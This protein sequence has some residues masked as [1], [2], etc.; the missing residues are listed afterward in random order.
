MCLYQSQLMELRMK[1]D[2]LKF[3]AKEKSDNL[4]MLESRLL[5]T[6][7]R[8]KAAGQSA[9]KMD[10]LLEQIRQVNDETMIGRQRSDYYKS[11]LRHC[12]VNP[13]RDPN[14]IESA[15]TIVN[16]LKQDIV[17]LQ[18]KT[19]VV[20]YEK[21]LASIEVPKLLQV[22]QDKSN[23]HQAALARLRWRQELNHRMTSNLIATKIA[24]FTGSKA[25][26]SSNQA[27]EF[28]DSG[29]FGSP[30]KRNTISGGGEG[31]SAAGAV[32]GAPETNNFLDRRTTSIEEA[33]FLRAKGKLLH[34]KETSAERQKKV[35]SLKQYIGSA[36]KDDGILGTLRQVGI[37]KPEEA[38]VYWQ[39][40]LDHATQLEAEEKLGEQ[41][42][43][44][45]REKLTAL[46]A[47]F[48]NLKLGGSST[49]NESSSSAVLSIASAG[50]QSSC[51][52]NSGSTN[53]TTPAGGASGG[54]E[55]VS[56]SHNIKLLEQ[57]LAE[58]SANNQQKK[59]R[60]ARLKLLSE[61]SSTD[62]V[63]I[64]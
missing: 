47:Q 12:E 46:Q 51:G 53:T 34:K 22:I 42:V 21:R 18:Q 40:Q 23:I 17:D 8:A 59:E 6:K 33:S 49:S 25:N 44:E 45:Y 14:T 5:D 1:Y 62:F 43:M 29:G 19:Q 28:R 15:E 32:A 61:V 58:T 11:I 48:V 38:Q 24:A 27:I 41:R 26:N 30:A 54:D 39:D 10:E 20:S 13:A 36:Y 16:K 52:I 55:G 2:K 7:A 63:Y 57:Q 60:A 31:L 3:T 64:V 50:G 4:K 35:E 56:K 9:S 37:N